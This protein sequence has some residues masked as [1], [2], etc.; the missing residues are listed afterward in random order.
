[1]ETS[2]KDID[3]VKEKL[4]KIQMLLQDILI[5]QSA[6]A[7]ITK[8]KTREIVGV[9]SSRVSRIWQHMDLEK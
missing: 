1:M 8:G 6:R 7:G 9:S 3:Q 4:D 2:N 5:I